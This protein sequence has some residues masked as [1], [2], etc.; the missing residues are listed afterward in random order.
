[1]QAHNPCCPMKNYKWG[2]EAD[3]MTQL[4]DLFLKITCGL[5]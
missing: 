4:V 2:M 3:E 1:M 5:L